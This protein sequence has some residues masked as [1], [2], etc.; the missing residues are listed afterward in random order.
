M[1]AS[2]MIEKGGRVLAHT[3]LS[4]RPIIEFNGK[5]YEQPIAFGENIG[6]MYQVGPLYAA[7][8]RRELADGTGIVGTPDPIESK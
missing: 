7:Q 4:K 2:E 5:I 6:E 3:G 1:T 8:I